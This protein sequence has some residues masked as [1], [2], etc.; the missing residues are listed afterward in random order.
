MSLR[1][2]INGFG[3]I[4]RLILRS[5]I[6]NNHKKIKVCAINDLG[7]INT[8]AHLLKYDSIHGPFTEKIIINGSCIKIKN[9]KIKVFSKK[10]PSTLPWKNLNI[11]LVMEC[12]GSFSTKNKALLHIKAGAKRVLI[13][14]PTKKADATIVY[15]V[16][17]KILK[18][19]HIIISNSSCTTH[20]LAPILSV[21]HKN[22]HFIRGYMITVHAYTADQNIVDSTGHIDLRRARAATNSIIPTSTGSIKAIELII[23]ELKGKINGHA[24][25]VPVSNVSMINLTFE[26]KEETSKEEINNSIKE[27]SQSFLKDIIVC[28]NEPLVSVDFNHNSNSC[29]FD[30][31]QTKVIHKN[32]CHISAWYDNEWG[33]ANS[34]NNLASHIAKL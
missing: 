3:R 8:N 29:I 31:S 28:I 21:L 16:N 4:G 7:N 30:P 12:S 5:I 14:A 17:H 1:V 27:A 19:Q 11:D 32:F 15:G 33:F 13:S 26:L 22:F 2:A 6:E 18:P 20:C 9:Q 34:M 25:R 10:N 23:P 24:V